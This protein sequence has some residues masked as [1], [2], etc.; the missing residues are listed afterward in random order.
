MVRNIKKIYPRLFFS[1]LFLAI[2]LLAFYMT[3]PFLP[4]LLTG[5]IIAYLA[6]PLYEKILKRVKKKNAASFIVSLL[7]VLLFT[8]P[9]IF[10][11]GLLSKEAYDTYTTINQHNLGT[12]FMK[13]VCKEESSISCRVFRSVVN[14]LPKEDLDYYL[15]VT[16][17]KITEFVIENGSRFI[18]SIS[19]ILLNFFVMVFVVYYLLRD[20]EAIA[21]RIK[22]ILPLK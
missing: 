3:K 2:L 10:V 16:I 12:N 17:K 20:G 4:A 22:N 6:Y 11:I 8:V 21:A 18:A 14:F 5:A 9:L 15:Q 19:S 13:I 1:V 7:I